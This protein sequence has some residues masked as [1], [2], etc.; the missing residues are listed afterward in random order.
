MNRKRKS[1]DDDSPLQD[2]DQLILKKLKICDSTLPSIHHSSENYDDD[3]MRRLE[4]MNKYLGELHHMKVQRKTLKILQDQLN[5][6]TS[7]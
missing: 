2:S 7:N 3:C 4:A 1:S 6:R 5:N